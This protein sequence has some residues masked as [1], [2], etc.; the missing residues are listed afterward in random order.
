MNDKHEGR[1]YMPGQESLKHRRDEDHCIVP[2]SYW[3]NL[4]AEKSDILDEFKNLNSEI[5]FD[6]QGKGK[7]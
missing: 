2:Y 4:Y 3:N 6:N 1:L 7:K 5:V